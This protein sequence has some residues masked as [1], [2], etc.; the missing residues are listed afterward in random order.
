MAKII[1][2]GEG[3]W[4]I[5][6]SFKI[7][8]LLDIGTQC[9][10]VR[11]S[12]G[13]FVM[14]DSYTLTE[15]ELAKI[16][17]ITGGRDNVVAVINLHPFHTLHSEAMHAAF[18]N[19]RHIGTQRHKL[20]SPDLTWDEITTE[21]LALTTEF[22]EDLDFSIPDG[23]MLVPAN[24]NIHCG[25][26]LAYHRPSKTIHVDDTFNLRGAT[27]LKPGKLSVH[28]TLK[29]ALERDAEAAP[30]FR[31]WGARL[32]SKW[33]DAQRI[34]AAHAGIMTAENLGEPS[35]QAAL[36]AALARAEKT[37]RKHEAR[38]S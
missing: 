37:L 14:L 20:K 28:L 3:F 6:G 7:A 27:K 18:S 13:R 24:E 25:S 35:V 36:T 9:S 17:A 8:G 34:C 38:Y 19:A 16:D 29:Q 22:A 15:D 31:D 5:R 26:I 33:A 21:E 2:C 12:D 23:V 1:D 10:L 4:N 11:L 30:A 32:T